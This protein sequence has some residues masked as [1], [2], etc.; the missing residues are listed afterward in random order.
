MM[1]LLLLKSRIKNFYEKHY[2]VV[3]SVMK[4]FLMFVS[5]LLL[6]EKLDYSAFAGRYDVILCLS[7][8]C[9][10]VPDIFSVIVLV[11]AAGWEIYSAVPMLGILFVAVILLYFLLLGRLGKGQEYVMAAIPLLSVIRL[12]YAVPLVAALFVSPVMIPALLMGVFLRFSIEGMKEYVSVSAEAGNAN[13]EM[14]LQPFHYVVDYLGR[15]RTFVVMILAFGITFACVYLIRRASY[16]HASQIA[17]LVG[18]LMMLTV[19]LFG[20]VLLDVEGSPLRFFM[21]AAAAMAIA[22]VVQFF[23]I[24]LD[25]HGTRKLQFEDDEY[26]YYV[27]AVPK[28]KVAVVDK[29]VTRIVTEET[30]EPADLKEELE[31]TLEMESADSETE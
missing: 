3:R 6:T 11:L 12:E 2:R 28:Y 16:K 21:Q 22:Y 4:F 29:T 14:F 5:M 17:I 8:L 26:Y 9:S 13:I 15:S 23:R 31:K 25:Y 20:N 19:E 10:V 24:T 18:T 1:T 30:E 27:T 7:L